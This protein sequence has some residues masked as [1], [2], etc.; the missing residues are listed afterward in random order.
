MFHES[1]SCFNGMADILD[2]RYLPI[3][4]EKMDLS[5]DRYGLRPPDSMWPDYT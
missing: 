5:I 4:A 2:R 3:A 1:R